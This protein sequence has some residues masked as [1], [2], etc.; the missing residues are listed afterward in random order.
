MDSGMRIFR[1]SNLILAIASLTTPIVLAINVQASTPSSTEQSA[2]MTQAVQ[3]PDNASTVKAEETPLP[4]AVRETLL[5]AIATQTNQ[6]ISK[7]RIV[8][9]RRETWSNGCLDLNRPDTLCTQAMVPGWLVLVAGEQQA[10]V[11]RTNESGSMIAL[12]ETATATITRTTTRITQTTTPQ[13]AG[14]NTQTTVREQTNRTSTTVQSQIEQTQTTQ[15]QTVLAQS[16]QTAVFQAIAQRTQINA[17]RLRI[18]EVRRKVWSDECLGLPS[19][20]T[21]TQ[22]QVP[23]WLVVATNGSNYWVYRSDRSGRKVVLDTLASELR[24]AQ[25]RTRGTRV[26]FADVTQTYWAYDFIRELAALDIIVGYPDGNYRPEQPVTRAELA[27]I[28][29]RTFKL[30]AV[31]NAR[32][33]TDVSSSYWAY[34]AIQTSYR[35]G[36]WESL[37][38][39]QFQPRASLTR[40][41]VLYTLARGLKLSTVDN[42]ASLL[43]TY[44]D[45]SSSSTANQ[46]LLAALTEEGIVVNYPDVRSLNLERI[47]TRAEVAAFIYQTL[48]SLSG[49]APIASPYIV[50]GSTV[51]TY[52]DRTPPTAE[53][54][55]VR[56]NCNQGIGNGAEGCD[57]G[58]SRPHGGSNDEGARR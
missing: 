52:G 15:Q 3:A 27:A 11:Y 21:C 40:S 39:S 53:G 30:A 4:E 57:P 37:V 8:E 12:D 54:D 17:S 23:G 49:V 34:S 44:T 31:R 43:S 45:V 48:V 29:R 7:L 16:V 28:L 14:T 38:S 24:T 33:F 10:W 58:N 19:T 36:F 5:R 42:I 55:R 18:A 25:I 13:P 50:P 26:T 56:R 32:P 9:A 47:T 22:A 51:V 2:A 20:Q 41:D 6:P 1:A 35:A 46:A